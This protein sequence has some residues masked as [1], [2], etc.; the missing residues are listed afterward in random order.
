MKKIYLWLIIIVV[1]AGCT[2]NPDPEPVKTQK[3]LN[4]TSLYYYSMAETAVQNGNIT[5]AVSLFNKADSYERDNI[6]IKSRLINVLSQQAL[7]TPDIYEEIITLGEEYVSRDLYDNDILLNLAEAYNRTGDYLAAE[8]YIKMAIEKKATMRL[9]TSYFIF[10]LTHASSPDISLL[11]KALEQPWTEKENVI[12]VAD[13]YRN[14][15]VLKCIAI[16]DSALTIWEDEELFGLELSLLET[17]KKDDESIE[18]LEKRI[19]K[20]PST[21]DDLKLYLLG[22][23]FKNHH[24]DKIYEQRKLCEDIGS[25]Q[26]LRYLFLAA[27]TLNDLDTSLSVARKLEEMGDSPENLKSTFYAYF[28]YLLFRKNLW[29]ESAEKL[30]FSNDINLI[31]DLIAENG[32]IIDTERA[33]VDTLMNFINEKQINPD[34]NNFLSGYVYSILED[35][36]SSNSYLEKVSLE[37]LKANDL[38]LTIAITYLNNS[39]NEL[40]AKEFLDQRE[41]QEPSFK[42]ILAQYYYTNKQDSLAYIKFM[43]ILNEDAEPE[44]G[45]FMLA[46]ILGEK[47]GDFENLL[48]VLEKGIT[49]YPENSE[50]MNAMGYLIADNS[51]EDKYIR[52]EELLDMALSLD[53]ENAMFWDSMAW[54][55]FKMEKYKK[56]LDAMKLPLDLGIENSEIAYH[57]G[58]IYLGLDKEK[59]AEKYYELAVELN[60]EEDSVNLSQQRL[61]ELQ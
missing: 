10:Q 39:G 23:Y 29:E 33:N 25:D 61:L 45:V 9:Y 37:Y 4:H 7:A 34:F 21:S 30:N 42:Q 15:D 26:S 14:I 22:L 2:A 17:L 1:L 44:V 55:Q 53:P 35:Q 52:A 28:S 57:L 46:S 31:L 41:I 16:L 24:F 54:I 32:L 58:E 36:E 13:L 12:L 47:N 19:A 49:L 27:L 40:K 38:L 5:S 3:K 51:I 43:E 8:K 56:A 6:Y 59:K 60:N 48:I 50:L 18:R 11:E 20:D